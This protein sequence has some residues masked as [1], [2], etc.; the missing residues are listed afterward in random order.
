MNIKITADSTCDLSPELIH[1]YDIEIIPLCV[2]K[3]GQ[4]YR[5]GVN[6]TSKDIFEHVE[7]GGELCTT[8]ALNVSE[9]QE[10]FAELSPKY[11]AVIHIGISN[12]FSSCIQNATIAAGEFGNVYAVDSRN[13]STGSG[14]VVIKAAEL[15]QSGMAPQEI[16][17]YLNEF[18][19]RV[20]AS[21]VI[22]KLDYLKKGGRCSSLAVLGAN[23]LNLKPCIEV[24]DGAMHV[25]K[26]Y[27]GSFEKCLLRYVK[28]RLEGRTDIDTGR[29]FITHPA[30]SDEV[31]EMVRQEVEKIMHF[32]EVLITRAGCTVSSHCGPNTLGILFVRKP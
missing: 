16:V 20:E 29:I 32:D 28:D 30:C 24:R 18:T 23:L 3:E 13:L 27:K 9:Y 19:A 15:A 10:V 5:D 1:K 26:K 7:N 4:P 11:D 2:I 12:G 17:D 22:D 6:I 31:V 21:F 14:H 25:A 8:S